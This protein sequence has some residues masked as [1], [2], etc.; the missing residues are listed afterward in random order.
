MEEEEKDNNWLQVFAIGFLVV[1]FV[2]MYFKF[3]FF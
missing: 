1:Y 3:I 2:F